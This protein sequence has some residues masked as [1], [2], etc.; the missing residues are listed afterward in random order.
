VSRLSDRNLTLDQVNDLLRGMNPANIKDYYNV[1]GYG[2][3]RNWA[4]VEVQ[5]LL[6]RL[7]VEYALEEH[8]VVDNSGFSSSYIQVSSITPE[9]KFAYFHSWDTLS[10][11]F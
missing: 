9:G 2:V 10:N 6:E 4:G 11:C 1:E 8:P 5:R 7:L 3:A